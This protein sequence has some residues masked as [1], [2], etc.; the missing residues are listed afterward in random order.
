MTGRQHPEAEKTARLESGNMRPANGLI[1]SFPLQRPASTA[2][3]IS[4]ATTH[5]VPG[6]FPKDIFSMC[7]HQRSVTGLVQQTVQIVDRF[8]LTI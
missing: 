5:L 3:S 4:L 7:A 2:F 8:A 6:A 1:E